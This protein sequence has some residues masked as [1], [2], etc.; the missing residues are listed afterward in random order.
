MCRFDRWRVST[1]QRFSHDDWGGRYGRRR[2]Y[3]FFSCASEDSSD[4][5]SG[6]DF[7]QRDECADPTL[8]EV[9][10]MGRS[11]TRGI[12]SARFRCERFE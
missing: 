12:L 8:L 5:E 3:R 10:S 7:G 2:P 1:R 4:V 9:P 6:T 11:R